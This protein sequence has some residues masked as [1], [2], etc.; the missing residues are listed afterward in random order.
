MFFSV[1]QE[2]A[3]KKDGLVRQR[4]SCTVPWF[5]KTVYGTLGEQKRRANEKNK[6]ASLGGS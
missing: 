2:G 4:K 5:A 3:R 1:M 6:G